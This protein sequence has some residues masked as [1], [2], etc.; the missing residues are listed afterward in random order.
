MLRSNKWFAQAGF[1]NQGTAGTRVEKMAKMAQAG[2]LRYFAGLEARSAIIPR[3][4]TRHISAIAAA[5]IAVFTL[6]CLPRVLFPATPVHGLSDLL[7]IVLPYMLVGAA[8]LAGYLVA[9]RAFPRGLKTAQPDIRMSIFGRWRRLSVIDAR[10]HPAF[11]PVGFMA[12][13]LV[14]MMLNVVIRSFEFLLAIPALNSHAPDWGIALFHMMTLD[15]VIL[16]FFYMA[17]FVLALRAVP[18]FPRLLVFTWGLDIIMQMAIARQIGSMADLPL[19]VAAPLQDLLHGNLT[20]VLISIAV[21]APYLI[22]SERVNVTYRL[23]ASA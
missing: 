19:A 5:W 23:R 15:V 8:P 14:G 10:A 12:S 18:W 22:L 11:G 13:L 21:W 4:L 7:E 20:K 6:A 2:L 1:A 17:C 3:L 9:C 16:S